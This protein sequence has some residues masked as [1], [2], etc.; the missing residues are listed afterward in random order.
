L[1]FSSIELRAKDQEDQ[2]DHFRLALSLSGR[3]TERQTFTSAL[4]LSS[5]QQTAPKGRQVNDL[6]L[7]LS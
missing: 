7:P 3:G 1:T 5:L 6:R 2:L 4:W